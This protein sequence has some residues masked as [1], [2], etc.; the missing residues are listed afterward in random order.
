MA[1]KK[2]ISGY[3]LQERFRIHV[4]DGVPRQVYVDQVLESTESVSLHPRQSVIS[5]LQSPHFDVVRE[6]PERCDVVPIQVQNVD[7]EA[8]LVVRNLSEVALRAV[9]HP[10]DAEIVAVAFVGTFQLEAVSVEG[11]TE[12]RG[13]AEDECNQACHFEVDPSIHRFTHISCIWN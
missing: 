9:G 1:S 5:Y 11:V 2:S 4:T 12:R 6:T 7:A 3:H 13:E 8:Q 10:V